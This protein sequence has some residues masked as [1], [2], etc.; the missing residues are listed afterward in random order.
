LAEHELATSTLAARVAA[1]TGARPAEIVQAGLGAVSG[2]L[3]GRAAVRVHHHLLH[4]RGPID[5]PTGTMGD[6]LG[7]VVH[8]AGDPR[9]TPLLAEAAGIATAA[10]R[11]RIRAALAVD[12]RGPQ[13]NVD[14]ALAALALAAG[15]EPGATEAIFAIARTAGWLAHGWEEADEPPLRY[16][17][18]TLH[19]GPRPS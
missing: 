19:R 4:G 9:A 17:G 2:P 16:R 6:G 3:H 7:H 14:A 11:R 1:S 15:A 10:Q 12:P 13:P 18:R 5:A 8:R